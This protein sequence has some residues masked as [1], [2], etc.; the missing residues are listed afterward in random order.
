MKI[1]TKSNS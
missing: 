1:V